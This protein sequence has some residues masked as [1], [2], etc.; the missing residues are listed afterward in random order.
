VYR[1]LYE[2]DLILSEA[3]KRIA[4]LSP[5]E[6]RI[7]YTAASPDLWNRR[8]E[9]GKSGFDLLHSGGVSRLVK[10]N[11]ARIARIVVNMKGEL[12]K[13]REQVQNIE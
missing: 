11:N 8:Q 4:S 7:R 12:E 13:I 9:S 2:K 6:G 3:G 10:A 1:E 5:E